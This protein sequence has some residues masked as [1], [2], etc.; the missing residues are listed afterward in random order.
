MNNNT[1]ISLAAMLQNI[2]AA[3]GKL[4]IQPKGMD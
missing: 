1:T 4:G 3:F 2:A